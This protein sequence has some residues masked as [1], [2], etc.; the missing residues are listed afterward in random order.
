[1]EL[2]LRLAEDHHPRHDYVD[3]TIEQ[4]REW[5]PPTHPDTVRKAPVAFD[6]IG[7]TVKVRGSAPGHGARRRL[8]FMD[9]DWLAQRLNTGCLPPAVEDDAEGEKSPDGEL[10]AGAYAPGVEGST[11][12]AEVVNGGRGDTE[13]RARKPT[14]TGSANSPTSRNGNT[15]RT[16]PEKTSPETISPGADASAS[17][18]Y[19]LSSRDAM[20]AADAALHG[21]IDVSEADESEPR[22]P[23]AVFAQARVYAEQR[24]DPNPHGRAIAEW[25]ELGCPSAQQISVLGGFNKALAMH[26]NGK[27]ATE[28]DGNATSRGTGT[29]R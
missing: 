29:G 7:L 3:S 18:N 10:T 8:A 6:A 17:A 23:L 13:R 1:V 22:A 16:S 11:A 5:L 20:P 21:V 27:E 26:R 2:V 12:G 4:L 24:R 28:G 25:H 14:T 15:P 19:R 9:P